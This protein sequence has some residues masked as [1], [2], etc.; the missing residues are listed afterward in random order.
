MIPGL[1]KQLGAGSPTY[2]SGTKP[3]QEGGFLP[4]LTLGRGL[5]PSLMKQ[6]GAGSPTYQSGTEPYQEGGLLPLLALGGGLLP[7]LMKQ[8]GRGSKKKKCRTPITAS[9][10]PSTLQR[11]FRRQGSRNVGV[12]PKTISGPQ[13]GMGQRNR[14]RRPSSHC[15]QG[16]P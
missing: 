7:G 8:L 15:F 11:L 10:I 9:S 3:Y 2:Q 1:M 14:R 6:L 4:L 16:L 12:L 5:L 13:V